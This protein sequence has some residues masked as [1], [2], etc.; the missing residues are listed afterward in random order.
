MFTADISLFFF[1]SH[2]ISSSSP[3]PLFL[4]SIFL[5]VH[6]SPL[7]TYWPSSALTSTTPSPFYCLPPPF[8]LSSTTASLP[9]SLFIPVS[10]LVAW[11]HSCMLTYHPYC[12]SSAHPHC[13]WQNAPS[14]G[15]EGVRKREGERGR[16]CIERLYICK[17]LIF[18]KA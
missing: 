10:I 17:R 13:K 4:H 8:L 14:E 15:S 5:W 3:L 9:L 6:P 1:S 11:V 7:I 12:A 16:M 2:F 18:E